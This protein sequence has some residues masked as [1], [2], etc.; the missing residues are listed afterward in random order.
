M[1]E[2]LQSI[3][4][5]M[6][7]TARHNLYAWVGGQTGQDPEHTAVL[8]QVL[9]QILA[10]TPHYM[11]AVQAEAEGEK[12]R[13][14]GDRESRGRDERIRE[15]VRRTDRVRGSMSE[16]NRSDASSASLMTKMPLA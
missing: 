10:D 7:T 14:G 15:G 4:L 1:S 12:E 13:G 16:R 2:A 9:F 6:H 3:L 5:K 8:S 11:H